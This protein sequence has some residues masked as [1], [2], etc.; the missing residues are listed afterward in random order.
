MANYFRLEIELGEMDSG[1]GPD[2]TAMREKVPR[3]IASWLALQA[4]GIMG[5][6]D[7]APVETIGD[8]IVAGPFHFDDD[9]AVRQFADLIEL[10]ADLFGPDMGH[11]VYLRE[12][13][14]D[15]RDGRLVSE[16]AF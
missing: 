10:A 2:W 14:R 11:A 4:S 3:F 15:G 7:P 16:I 1:L 9:D 12:Y 5:G 8:V 13:E 6:P